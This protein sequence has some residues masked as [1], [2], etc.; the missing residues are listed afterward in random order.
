MAE[1]GREEE[2]R[3]PELVEGSQEEEEILGLPSPEGGP[4]EEGPQ[5]IQVSDHADGESGGADPLILS[6]GDEKNTTRR[7][8]Q[9]DE[10]PSGKGSA[11][12][13]KGWK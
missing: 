6:D 3:R 7:E 13:G 10:D 1:L 9:E 12:K 8:V 11:S 2:A 5:E 4:D